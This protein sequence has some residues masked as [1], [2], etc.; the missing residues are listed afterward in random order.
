[1]LLFGDLFWLLHIKMDFTLQKR[2]L[3]RGSGQQC[4]SFLKQH[5]VKAE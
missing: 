2:R 5:F 1:M 4:Y 3:L